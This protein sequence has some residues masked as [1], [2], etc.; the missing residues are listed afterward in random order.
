MIDTD[1]ANDIA[2]LANSLVQAESLLHSL[3]QA[4]RGFGLYWNANKIE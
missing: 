1:Y 2:F 3:Q 4:P